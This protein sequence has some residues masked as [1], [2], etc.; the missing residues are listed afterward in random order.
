MR[1]KD[2]NGNILVEGIQSS[3]DGRSILNVDDDVQATIVAVGGDR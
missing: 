3:I 2:K 1:V